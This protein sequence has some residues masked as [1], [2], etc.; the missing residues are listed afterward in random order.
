[1]DQSPEFCWI[2][3]VAAGD[4]VTIHVRGEIDRATVPL[5]H[6][7]LDGV[8]GHG[9]EVDLSATTFCDGAGLRVLEQAH[10]RFGPRLRVTGVSPLLLRLAAI[11]EMQ[12]LTADS[13]EADPPVR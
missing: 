6:A 2:D 8:D 11:L 4:A 12:W 10:Q 7:A 1:M 5:L 13:I 3:V 9:V